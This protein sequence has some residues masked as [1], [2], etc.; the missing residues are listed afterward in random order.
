MLKTLQVGKAIK[1][2]ECG[3]STILCSRS[4]KRPYSLSDSG[5]DG[6]FGIYLSLLEL[7]NDVNLF[8]YS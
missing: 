2:R 5:V 4:F 1:F 3:F 6:M 8:R 7:L